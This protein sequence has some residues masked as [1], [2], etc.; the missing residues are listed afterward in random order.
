[1][2]ARKESTLISQGIPLALTLVIFIILSGLLYGEIK[3]LNLFTDTDIVAHLQW[4]DILVGMTIYLKTSVDFAIFIGNLMAAY[5]G[6]KNRVAIEIGTA[7]GNALG[8]VAV[9]ALWDFFRAVE[10]LLATM[11]FIAALVLIRL[12]EDG[13]EHALEGDKGFPGWFIRVLET[14]QKVLNRINTTVDPFL[15]LII[16]HVS[17]KSSKNLTWWGLFASSFTIPFILGL[18]DFAGYVPVFNIVNV[19]GFS[20]GVLAGHMILNLF[21]F[22]SPK[23]TIAIVKNPVISFI[24]SLAFIALALWGFWEVYKILILHHSCT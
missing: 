14:F 2:E 8:T 10:W 15:S 18:D 1:M 3:L 7:T 17:M 22:L 13:I 5:P 16:P 12:A 21:L 23:K 19:F 6:W 9:L 24:G 4:G 11:I 20:I